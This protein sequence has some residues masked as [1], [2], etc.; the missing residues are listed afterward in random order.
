MTQRN[1]SEF[2]AAFALYAR[3]KLAE[4]QRGTMLIRCTADG[5]V[6]AG[7]YGNDNYRADS[8]SRQE[9]TLVRQ[10]LRDL[11]AAELGFALS[12]DGYTW[13]VLVR[14]RQ[15]P[16]LTEAGK[17]FQMEMLKSTLE[18]AVQGA[19]VAAG[20]GTSV[21]SADRPNR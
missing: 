16:Y 20:E 21:N 13:A 18:E 6:L 17:H 12:P 3:S 8:R 10:R 1:W 11:S 15:Q 2:T 5:S 7:V 9:A 19:W 14:A 4:T